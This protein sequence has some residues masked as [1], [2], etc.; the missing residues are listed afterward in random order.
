M[1]RDLIVHDYLAV[2]STFAADA[3]MVTG[4]GVVKDFTAKTAGF[5]AAET[6][7]DIMFVQKARIP[8]GVN[9]ARTEFSD[10]DPDFVN[11][12]KGEKIT[13]YHYPADATFGTDQFNVETLTKGNEGKRVAW[14]EDGKA[15]IA[16]SSVAS[17][18]VFKGLYEEA[19]GRTLAEIYVSD[20][21]A[22]NS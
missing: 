1:L 15:T 7:A 8:T 9:A 10:Y 18:Y 17:V 14:G 13:L 19:K 21:P 3:D 2:D 22:T 16:S 12:A 20:T 11:V 4:A 6:A 5:P